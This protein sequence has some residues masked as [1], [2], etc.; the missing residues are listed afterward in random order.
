MA[1][2]G[3]E[4]FLA[5]WALLA[6]AALAGLGGAIPGLVIGVP[7]GFI[8]GV[9]LVLV[10]R[11]LSA[12]KRENPT[13]HKVSRAWLFFFPL[14]TTLTLGGVGGTLGFQL[15]ALTTLEH[16]GRPACDGVA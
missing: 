5:I 15:A 6:P 10:L 16:T 2:A 9:V 3:S 7:A 8:F 4:L 1:H 12:F 14:A 11:K 13:W